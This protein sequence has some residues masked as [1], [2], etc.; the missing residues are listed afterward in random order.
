MF[1]ERKKKSARGTPRENHRFRIIIDNNTESVVFTR[2][3]ARAS[4]FLPVLRPKFDAVLFL[5]VL[6]G[7]VLLPALVC[8][9]LARRLHVRPTAGHNR[10]RQPLEGKQQSRC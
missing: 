2:D 1:L 8:V 3:L 4:F 10:E 7:Q 6:P 5:Y 9:D